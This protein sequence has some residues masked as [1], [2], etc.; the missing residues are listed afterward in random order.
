[1]PVSFCPVLVV[2]V[3]VTVNRPLGSPR[4]SIAERRRLPFTTRTGVPLT[5]TRAETIV[6]PGTLRT[7]IWNFRRLAQR[8]VDGK[9]ITSEA[10]SA[11]T[12]AAAW[13]PEGWGQPV[14]RARA[15]IIRF[16]SHR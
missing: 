11:G 9:A 16:I 6:R 8:F 5:F 2:T 13:R 1:L 4:R 14:R 3:I 12:A 7:R 10:L 15:S